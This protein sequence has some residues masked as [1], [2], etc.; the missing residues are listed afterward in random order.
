MD[1]EVNDDFEE[2][3]NAESEAVTT[4]DEEVREL[5]E[6]ELESK[7]NRQAGKHTLEIRRA[8][9]DHLEQTRLR[10]E[11]DYLFDEDFPEEDSE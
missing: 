9:E 3:L 5:R 8:I 7:K 11:L 6:E 10:K 2:S 1:Y 4:E